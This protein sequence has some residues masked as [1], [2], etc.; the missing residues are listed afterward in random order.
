MKDFRSVVSEAVVC[1]GQADEAR[2]TLFVEHIEKTVY[3]ARIFAS[4]LST[5]SLLDDQDFISIALNTLWKVTERYDPTFKAA[6]W[7]FA[8]TRINGSMLDELRRVDIVSRGQREIVKQIEKKRESLESALGREV[9]FEAACAA[10]GMSREEIS[11]IQSHRI[12]FIHLDSTT[13]DKSGDAEA[14][15]YQVAEVVADPNSLHPIE[16]MEPPG[17]VHIKELLERLE[18]MDRSIIVLYYWSELRL[19]QIAFS[20]EVTESRVC[21]MLGAAMEKLKKLIGDESR[22]VFEE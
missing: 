2:Y 12:K 1:N 7:T 13:G 6:F 5:E 16:I 3:G 22:Q 19:N 4:N 21:Q 10:L 15:G 14:D 20:L 9:S 8:R 17:S 18:P 11:E